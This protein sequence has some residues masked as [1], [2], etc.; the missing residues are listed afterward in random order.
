M[1][2]LDTN[3]L[4]YAHRLD[5]PEHKRSVAATHR[6]AKQGVATTAICVVEF[7]S[8]VT[9]EGYAKRHP[10][11][12]TDCATFLADFRTQGSLAILRPV[13]DFEIR[14]FSVA[15]KLGV[16][17]RRL[18]DLAIGLIAL[19]GGARELWTHDETFVAP[20]GLRVRTPLK[21]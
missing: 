18:H 6:A 14:L 11:S 12:V 3:L 13:S 8:V 5:S 9:A 1:I 17:G 19:E 2:A 21:D 16:R 15:N 7:V 10:S 20:P 4:I